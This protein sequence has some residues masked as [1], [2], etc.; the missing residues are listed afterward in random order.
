MYKGD[1][2]T[3]TVD[4]YVDGAVITSWTSSGN[5][6]DFET[7]ALGVTGSTI[8]LRGMLE[9]SEWLSIMEV[10]HFD[11][12]IVVRSSIVLLGVTGISRA[13]PSAV[14]YGHILKQEY[15]IYS[16]S[17]RKKSPL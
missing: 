4:I 7:V 14:W 17:P 12:R 16:G 6:L 13:N 11:M 5:T 9:D 1:E 8:E 2:R 3:R 10:R 15:Y